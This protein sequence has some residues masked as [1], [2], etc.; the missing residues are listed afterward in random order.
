MGR[1]TIR[2][3]DGDA[4]YG[5][6]NTDGSNSVRSIFDDMRR[7]GATARMMLIA[8]AAKRWNVAPEECIAKDHKVTHTPT[9]THIRVRRTGLEAG[10][11]KVPAKRRRSCSDLALNS[12]TSASR[13]RC[14]TGPRTLPERQSTGQTSNS[15]HAHGGDCAAA[16]GGRQSGAVRSDAR[17]WPCRAS[18]R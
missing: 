16:R 8:A 18:A 4:V 5:D 17:L 2:Q 9:R 3:A 13:C 15:R 1:V 12:Y 7:V 14:S 11:Q 10:R 6:Q